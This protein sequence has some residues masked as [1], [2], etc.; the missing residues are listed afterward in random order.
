[1][2]KSGFTLIEILVALVISIILSAST[3]IV[4]YN[5]IQSTE[6]IKTIKEMKSIADAENLF[7]ESNTTPISCTVTVGGTNYPETELYHIYTSNFSDLI[8]SGDLASDVK[9]VNYFS[10][11]YYLQPTYSAITVN[12]NNYCVRESSIL[13]YTY[14]PVSESDVVK[15]VPGAFDI[16]VSGN[17]E[18]VGYYSITKEN[19]SEQDATLKYNW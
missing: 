13:V 14:I 4:Y 12:K 5:Y 17:M 1:M 2:N 16:S 3:L 10:Q 11:S 8:N 15:T 19:D 7:Y 6:A 18:E 9:D